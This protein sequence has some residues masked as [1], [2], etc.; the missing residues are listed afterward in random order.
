MRPGTVR[1]S[2]IRARDCCM[3]QGWMFCAP[4]MR[5][6][7]SILRMSRGTALSKLRVRASPGHSLASSGGQKPPPSRSASLVPRMC[8]DMCPMGQIWPGGVS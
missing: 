2:L 7:Q 5:E 6:G 3:S 8:M 1:L 4:G